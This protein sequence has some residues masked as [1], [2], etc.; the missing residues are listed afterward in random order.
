MKTKIKVTNEKGEDVTMDR[1]N[2]IGQ[3]GNSG[4]HYDKIEDANVVEY[5]EKN[6]PVMAKAFQ[7]IQFEQ[8]ELFCRKQ[9]N[10][11][12]GNIMLGGDIDNPDDRKMALSGVVIRMNDKLNRLMNLILKNKKDVVDESVEDTFIDMANYAIIAQLVQ[13]KVWGK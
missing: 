6:Y 10:Y 7:E 2:I 13:K 12:K 11:G 1:L 4:L 9:Y 8:Y 5:I 3:N